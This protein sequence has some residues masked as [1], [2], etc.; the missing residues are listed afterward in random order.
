MERDSLARMQVKVYNSNLARARLKVIPKA[1]VRA[2]HLQISPQEPPK[3][4]DK[5]ARKEAKKE[6]KV[7]ER[8]TIIR[9][10]EKS[11]WMEKI[12]RKK[13]K[14]G[15]KVKKIKIGQNK[16]KKGM[17]MTRMVV[18]NPRKYHQKQRLRNKNQIQN[19]RRRCGMSCK[20]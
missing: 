17:V 5:V 18:M 2:N 6:L 12:Q 11:M 7:E 19:Y 3:E 10:P 14:D 1:K 9:K 20:P 8:A 15:M 13:V 4:E 16:M